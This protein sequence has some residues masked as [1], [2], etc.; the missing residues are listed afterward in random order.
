MLTVD[1]NK[2]IEWETLFNHPIVTYLENK[3]KQDLEESMKQ[4]E[5]L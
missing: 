2:R 1:A 4:T 3:L 5:D